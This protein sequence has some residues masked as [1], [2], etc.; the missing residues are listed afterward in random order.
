MYKDETRGSEIIKG[1][2]FWKN[3]K[4]QM[5]VL[6][7]HYIADLAKDPEREGKEWFKNEQK[8]ALKSLW[9]KEM[10]IDFTTKSGKLIYGS[11][12]C[13]FNKDIH[14][15]NSF[16]H[17]EPYELLISLD[18]GQRNPTGALIGL[19][20]MENRLYII[21]E[22]YNPALP[23]VSSREMFKKFAYL[24]GEQPI[25]TMS[26][27]RDAVLNTFSIKVI[28]PTTKS[29]NRSVIKQ[30]EEVEYSIIEEFYDNGWNFDLGS[31]DVAS[32]ITRVREYMRL[33]DN[34]PFLYIF[35]DK[36]PKLCWEIQNYKYKEHSEIQEKTRNDSE[37]P[38]KKN[39]HLC[40]AM[41][42]M[43]LTRPQTPQLAPKPKTKIQKDIENCSKPQILSDFDID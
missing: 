35:K 15:I 21:D 25:S 2:R 43:I 20:T 27:K 18:F 34:K 1:L 19:W 17:Q 38:V 32:G 24:F 29:K 31:N 12:F 42:Y 40:D 39:D 23:S 10:E 4:N 13:D 37:E 33:D 5:A 9:K 11:E 8:G 22:Y 3:P 6:M 36:C 26:Q 28:D 7:L 30:G 14:F 41:R 16:R